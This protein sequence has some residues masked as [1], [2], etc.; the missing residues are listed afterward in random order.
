MRNFRFKKI[1]AF[2]KAGSSGNPAAC[3][4]LNKEA[5]CDDMQKIAQELKGYVSEV[6]YCLPI[7]NEDNVNYSLL[8]YSSECE[9]EFCGHGTIA[10]MYDLVTNT[11]ELIN[12]KEIG[13]RTRKGDLT[14]YNKL[15][16]ME[17]VF[18]TAP[19]PEYNGT[20][21]GADTISENLG[22]PE[23]WIDTNHPIDLINA[24]LNTLIVPINSLNNI[25]SIWPNMSSLKDFCLAN[26]ID[27]I[28]VFTTEVHDASNKIHTRV[29]APKYGYLEDP[30]TGSGN[31]AVGYYF[32]KNNLWKG[33]CISIE[34]GPSLE[35]AN[36]IK[37]D[38][39]INAD[40]GR[41]VLFGGSAATRIDGIY[42]LY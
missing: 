25:V 2:T 23:A 7:D 19:L 11:P 18:I 26:H 5:E 24:G 40:G 4:Y 38:T 28:T 41:Q 27:I 8:Y 32:L 29:F 22:I 33:H 34:Q 17:A 35:A 13:I 37:L 3:V 20:N 12:I 14:V 16:A 30:A 9:V 15:S 10:C 21:L 36:I 42:T 1:D 6:V 39:I 31:S